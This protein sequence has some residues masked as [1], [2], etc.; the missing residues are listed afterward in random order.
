[1]PDNQHALDL[2][3]SPDGKTLASVVNWVRKVVL[4]DM[5]NKTAKLTESVS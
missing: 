4:W 5:E 2:D 3:Y 1:M